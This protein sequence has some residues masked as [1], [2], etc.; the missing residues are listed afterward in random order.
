LARFVASSDGNSILI[1]GRVGRWYFG[2][3]ARSAKAR[4]IALVDPHSL[5]IYS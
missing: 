2:K 3:T 4:K 1:G 5:M